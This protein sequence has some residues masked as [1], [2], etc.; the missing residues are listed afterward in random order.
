MRTRPFWQGSW[1]ARNVVVVE[2]KGYTIKSGANLFTA[3][4]YGHADPRRAKEAGEKVEALLWS[5]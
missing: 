5:R 4:V 2:V 1:S 3:N